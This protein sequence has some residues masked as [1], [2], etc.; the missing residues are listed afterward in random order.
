VPRATWGATGVPSYMQMYIYVPDRMA[1]KPPI[2]ISCHSCGSTA[3]NQINNLPVTKAQADAQGFIIL[4]PDNQ[5]NNCWDVGTAPSLL[6]NG[7]GDTKAIVDQV[8]YTVATYGAN[9]DRVYVTG[10]S[11]GGM[12]TEA[13]VAAYPDVFKGGAEFAVEPA[14]LVHYAKR[15]TISGFRSFK[16]PV[17][18]AKY[19]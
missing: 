5:P 16:S 8:K 18:F 19:S 10:S 7:G 3:P 13:I 17:V 12:V 1:T 2:Y 6:H 14:G 11:S 4:L 15:A 9:G